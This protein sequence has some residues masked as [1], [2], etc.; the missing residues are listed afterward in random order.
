[1]VN[2]SLSIPFQGLSALNGLVECL[3]VTYDGNIRCL[4][5]GLLMRLSILPL[6]NWTLAIL[7]AYDC[8]SVSFYMLRNV[9]QILVAATRETDQ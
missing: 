1:M 5:N 4:D 6:A 8:G 3:S 9:L 2:R 7:Y